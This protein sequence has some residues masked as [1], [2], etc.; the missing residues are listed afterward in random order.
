VN[1]LVDDGQT[2]LDKRGTEKE[3]SFKRM[4]LPLSYGDRSNAEKYA[5]DC[6]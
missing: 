3:E 2:G 1:L 5:A 6:S 4:M